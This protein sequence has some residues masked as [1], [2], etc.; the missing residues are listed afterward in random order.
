VLQHVG[1]FADGV[2]KAELTVISGTGELQGAAGSELRVYDLQNGQHFTWMRAGSIRHPLWNPAGDQLLFGARDSTR[3]SVLRGAPGSGGQPDT[4]MNSTDDAN[5]FDPIDYLNDHIALA[6]IWAGSIVA[7]FDPGVPH[8]TF[9]T[10]LTGARFASVAPSQKLILYQT[11]D[12]NEVIVT[13]FPVPGRRWRLASE[14]VEPLWLSSTDVLY[15]VGTAWYLVRVDPETGE[16]RGAPAFWA[17][18]PRF[19]DTSGWSNR[20]SRDGGIIYVQGP[21]ENSSSY[22]RVIPDWVRQMKATVDSAGR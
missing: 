6:Q 8:P 7:R 12:G 16:P 19:S 11:L 4:L 3:W 20:P 13:G 22:L 18:D 9:D 14:G 15:R 5:N 10:L 21:V 1:T 17:R 2:A